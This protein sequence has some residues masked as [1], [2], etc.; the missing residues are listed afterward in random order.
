MTYGLVCIFFFFFFSSRR[1][2]TRYISVTGVQTC[3]LPIWTLVLPSHPRGAV[4]FLRRTTGSGDVVILKRSYRLP[5]RWPH[6]LVRCEV[7]L[8]TGEIRFFGLRRQAHEQ[9]PLL[10]TVQ[11]L[12]PENIKGYSLFERSVLPRK[13]PLG[14]A[15]VVALAQ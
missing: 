11:Y 4:I 9:Q 6:R 1:R 13:G 15:E 14:G 10:H 5:V 2:H 7:D 12:L 3:A 8:D